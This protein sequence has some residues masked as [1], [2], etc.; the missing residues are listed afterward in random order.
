MTSLLRIFSLELTALIRSWTAPMLL[1]ASLAWLF[2]AERFVI[3]DSTA[4]GHREMF[5]RYGLGGVFALLV[6][7]LLA[8]AT[9]SIASE[10]EAKRLQLTQ[11]RPV[12]PFAIAWG[13]FLALSAVGAAVLAV[14]C[15]VV[16]LSS[17]FRG[18][19]CSHVFHPSMIS[20]REEAEKMYDF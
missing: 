11:V 15:A 19:S 20:P 13:K 2:V 7:S 9:G 5:I 18:R 12:S 16:A 1:A 8:A 14:S 17:D 3:T 10:R 4:E 6:I